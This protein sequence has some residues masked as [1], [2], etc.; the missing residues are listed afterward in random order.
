MHY[1]GLESSVE[2]AGAIP[3]GLVPQQPTGRVGGTNAVV[4]GSTAS[5][6]IQIGRRWH[7]HR[8]GLLLAA[9][10]NFGPSTSCASTSLAA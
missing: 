4:V 6:W 5:L 10:G 9:T 1:G 7:A 2:N 8:R 3:D